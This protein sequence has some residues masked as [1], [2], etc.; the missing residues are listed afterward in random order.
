MSAR[1]LTWAMLQA[2][3]QEQQTAYWQGLLTRWQRN[4]ER[5][6]DAD[7]AFDRAPERAAWR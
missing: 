3:P 7:V 1:E 6:L 4:A 5:E 2:L